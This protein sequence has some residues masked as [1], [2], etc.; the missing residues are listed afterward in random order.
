MSN[1]KFCEEKLVK[2]TRA[3]IAGV[4]FN[5]IDAAGV[6]QSVCRWRDYGHQGTVSLVNPHSVLLCRRDKEMERAIQQ[7]A[8]TLP[9]GIGI[10]IGAK[11]LSYTHRGRVSGPELL[12]YICDKGRQHGL[13]HYFYGGESGVADRIAVNLQRMFPGLDVAGAYSPPFREFSDAEVRTDIERINASRPSVLWIGLGAPKQEKWMARYREEV[14]APAMIGVGAAF[15]FHSGNKAWCP[16]A[17]RA[18]GLEWAYRLATEPRRL[19]LRNLD[20]L[21]FLALVARQCLSTLNAARRGPQDSI[22]R[23]D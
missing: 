14:S 7:S 22:S 19:W 4:G 8:I 6:L 17:L 3:T 9:D 21:L 13:S 11:A 15:D 12:L 20:S 23:W 2:E 16:A 1:V 5:L 10:I 18:A